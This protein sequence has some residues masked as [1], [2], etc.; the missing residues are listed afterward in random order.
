MLDI[1]R[2]NRMRLNPKPRIQRIVALSFL[3]PNY[4]LPPR[5]RITIDGLER[6][7]REPVVYAMNHTDRYNYWP[8]QYKLWRQANRFT[9]TWVKGKYYENA[10]VATF[11]ELTNNI[12]TVSRGYIITKDFVATVGRRPGEHEYTAL[13]RWVDAAAGVTSDPI[14]PPTDIPDALLTT[15]RSILGRP[16]EPHQETYA[17]A[18][19]A[20]FRTMMARFV[21]LNREGFEKGL[22]L[23]VFPQ[24]TRSK[25]LS[26]GHIG[27]AQIALKHRRT[28]VPIGCNGADRAYPGSSPIARASEVVYRVGEP[29]PYDA[30]K[31]FHVPDF[32]PFTPE[33][34]RLHRNAF[35]GFVDVVMDRID[36]LLD[37]EYR[38]GDDK[39][40]GGVRGSKR[41]V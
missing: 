2:M 18:I 21:E 8:F 4:E 32:A 6:I 3:L 16:F 5:V 11:M 15:P 39:S 9:A 34:E 30:M 31:D 14:T 41:F 27:L 28:I 24:G 33:A 1:P 25:R 35:Q 7:P 17:A 37:P 29:I 19:D 10:F 38:Y 36:A 13:R 12:P 22:D 26:R 23:L 40:S 20:V